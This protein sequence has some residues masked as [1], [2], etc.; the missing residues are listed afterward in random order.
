MTAALS[1]LS[2]RGLALLHANLPQARKQVEALSD[3]VIRA[4]L[5]RPALNILCSG[6]FG[7][8]PDYLKSLV[9]KY[10]QAGRLPHVLFY[11]TNG[12]AGRHWKSQVMQGFGSRLPPEEFRRKILH[13]Q[14]FQRDFQRLARRL[15][16]IITDIYHTGG[17]VSVVPQL[18]DNQ[19]D[20]S[21]AM[22]LEISRA[23]L[24]QELPI[25]FG[26][27]PCVS[28]YP[29]NQ[30]GLPAGCFLEEHHHSANTDFILRNGVLSNDGC[31]YSFPGET[32]LYL[33]HLPLA[34]FAGV[35]S[36]T[37]LMNSAFILW[38]AKYQG[39]TNRGT[40]PEGRDYV[41]PT[42]AERE[43]LVKF[44]RNP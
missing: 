24:P 5:R 13:D 10:S 19:T 40:D 33:P 20:Q 43:I 26:R 27:N 32:P 36:R 4:G 28:C 16:D 29:G 15:A 37:G 42:E 3:I 34:D 12:P 35:Q 6:D 21:F 44:L 23:A 7:W 22:M 2:P 8:D 18:E 14:Q 30:G 39:L 31:T 41:M 25:R 9:H 11:L 38:N 17:Q 1:D